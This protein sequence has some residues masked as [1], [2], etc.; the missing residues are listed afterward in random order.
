MPIDVP[1]TGW[2]PLLHA[3]WARLEADLGCK[4]PLSAV[5]AGGLAALLDLVVAWSRRVDLTAARSA[6]ELVDLYLADAMVI[7][8][9]EP[10]TAATR[11]IDVGSGGGAPGLV[12]ALLRPDANL[13][14]VEPRTKRTA[15]L[16]AAKVGIGAGS[17]VVERRR[18][19]TLPAAGWQMALSRA[20]LPPAA[21]LAEGARLATQA[22]WVLLAR[23]Q[24]PVDPA[25]SV[26]VELRYR[27]PHTGAERRALRYERRPPAGA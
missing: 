9:M 15:F 5:D 4:V 7:A 23:G 6:E 25:W 22:V 13:T 3:G 21:W 1:S 27:L 14:L 26:A 8:A 19:E 2:L 18:S 11:W 10:A 24:P 20:T 16:R 17:V 12:L